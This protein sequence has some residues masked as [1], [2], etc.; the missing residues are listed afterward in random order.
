MTKQQ[1]DY[2]TVPLY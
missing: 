1:N 2:N